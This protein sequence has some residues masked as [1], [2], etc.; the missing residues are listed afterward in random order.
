MNDFVRLLRDEM[1]DLDVA[2]V[3]IDTVENED[4]FTIT[5]NSG[6]RIQFTVTRSFIYSATF[7]KMVRKAR[8]EVISQTKQAI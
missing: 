4:L 5:K 1:L 2:L 3:E 7:A 8:K 6:E